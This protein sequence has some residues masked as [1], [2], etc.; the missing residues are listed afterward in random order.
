M[1]AIHD[2][3]TNNDKSESII[4]LASVGLT[5]AN[6]VDQDIPVV[7]TAHPIQCWLKPACFCEAF[8]EIELQ[9]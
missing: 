4:H 6:W 8:G 3:D 5:S 2:D 9:L 1:Y 7:L